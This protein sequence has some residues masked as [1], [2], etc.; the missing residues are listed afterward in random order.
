M[1]TI[2]GKSLNELG[3]T[4][5][6]YISAI[7]ELE[8]LEK[9]WNPRDKLKCLMMMQ[10]LMRSSVVEF[11]RG[12]EELSSMDDELPIVIFIVLKSK[13]SN[14]P[15]DLNFIEH[16][17]SFES[18]AEYERRLLVNLSNSIQFIL[19]ELEKAWKSQ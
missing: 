17:I 12:R 1:E 10:S 11:Y 4:E 7:N 18:D 13:Y 8:K 3:D 2:P 19:T 5:I 9:L 14:L 6:P 15:A 16:Y